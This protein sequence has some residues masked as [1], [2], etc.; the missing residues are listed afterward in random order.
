[1]DGPFTVQTLEGVATG[2][3]GD[4]LCRGVEGEKWPMGREKFEATYTPVSARFEQGWREYRK[5][6]GMVLARRMDKSF[7]VEAL[8]GRLTGQ[9]GDY[10]CRD[11]D[12]NEWPVK[13]S[14]FEVSYKLIGEQG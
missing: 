6:A 9:A 2:D 12:N 8:P 5:V 14:I 1:M 11:E 10:L 4:Y 7:I 13:A 3:K